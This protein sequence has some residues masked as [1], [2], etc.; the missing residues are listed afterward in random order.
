MATYKVIQD[1]EAE[2]KL[3][4]PLTLRQFIYG[5]VAALS[6]YFC[7]LGFAKHLYV[8]LIVFLPIM[9]LF[10]F[11]AFPWGRDQPTEVWALAKVRFLFL[12]RKRIWDQSGA[13]ELV[14]VTAPKKISTSYTDNLSQTEVKSR[15][16]A[17]ADTLDSRGWVT[18]NVDP[19]N[20]VSTVAYG[21]QSDRL[22]NI[23][24]M[25]REVSDY[26]V[27]PQDDVMD[28]SSRTAATFDQMISAAQSSHRQQLINQMQS[29]SHHQP[30]TSQ[31][32]PSAPD[33]FWFLNQSPS[34]M[35]ANVITPGSEASDD[36]S[37]DDAA[38]AEQLKANK[39]TPVVANMHM[40]TIQPPSTNSSNT[41]VVPA[42]MAPIIPADT[43]TTPAPAGDNV[44]GNA[45]MEQSRRAIEQ[46]QL[47]RNNDLN[48]AT[49]ARQVNRK[50][51]D[52]EVEI[53]L[54]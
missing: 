31:P 32:S 35:P 52:N 1:I 10:G 13:K 44:T 54:H 50:P 24:S 3:L 43:E 23:A 11:F 45:K 5:A 33:N 17:L 7:F 28:D 4:G 18:K 2:D 22:I 34:G 12:P 9:L 38:L 26:N 15:L 41:A 19:A 27:L 53:K 40:R 36:S 46:A 21:A 47:A 16:Q 14:T 30:A 37:T 39:Q 29:A 51:E 49:I 20:A 6:G 48:I 42:S 8:L 25:P